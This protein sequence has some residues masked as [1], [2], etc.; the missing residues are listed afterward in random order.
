MLD[1]LLQLLFSCIGVRIPLVPIVRESSSFRATTLFVWSPI[2]MQ[3]S[4]ADSDEVDEI[5]C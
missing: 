3:P 5:P 2:W 4:A 1:M